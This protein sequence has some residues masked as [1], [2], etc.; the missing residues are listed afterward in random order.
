MLD[1]QHNNLIF[2]CDSCSEVL[3]TE[4]RDFSEAL[5]L[6]RNAG[7]RAAKIGVDWV[8]TCA[9]CASSGQ[10]RTDRGRRSGRI[11]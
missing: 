11:P 4:T 10:T 3:E 7:W 5:R 6:M 8:H 1:R 2:E 9:Q